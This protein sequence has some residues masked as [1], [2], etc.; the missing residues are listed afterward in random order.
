MPYLIFTCWPGIDPND[1][2]A[3]IERFGDTEPEG[4]W[5]RSLGRCSGEL[6]VFEVWEGLVPFRR[7]RDRAMSRAMVKQHLAHRYDLRGPS[8]AFR[9]AV[10]ATYPGLVR[11]LP[12]S[13]WNAL[14]GEATGAFFV[15]PRITIARYRE[16][17]RQTRG[18]LCSEYGNELLFAADGPH[19]RDSWVVAH[20]WRSEAA[21]QAHI[22]RAREWSAP[23]IAEGPRI[24]RVASLHYA[25]YGRDCP[26]QLHNPICAE[27]IA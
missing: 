22:E 12:R 13:Q 5:F 19:G 21:R 18:V 2:P 1:A 6:V 25:Y 9:C 4:L 10:T 14:D 15:W 11:Q 23:H 20:A 7:Y 17:V 24:K 16:A 3:T 27:G 8:F 26:T